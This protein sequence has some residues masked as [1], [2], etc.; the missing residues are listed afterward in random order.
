M[1]F[2]IS[3]VQLG[4]LVIDGWGISCEIALWWM[5]MELTDKQPTL[6]LVMAWCLQATNVDLLSVGPAEINFG[7]IWIKTTKRF[8]QEN[9]FKNVVCK[10]SVISGFDGTISRLGVKKR[11]SFT[12]WQ[13]NAHS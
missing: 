12:I 4:I 5:T 2:Y 13:Y 9:A 1:R 6:V 11:T 3:T 8:F 7:E 10:M